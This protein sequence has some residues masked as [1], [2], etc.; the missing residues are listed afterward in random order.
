MYDGLGGNALKIR[1]CIL[2]RQWFLGRGNPRPLEGVVPGAFVHVL[3][4]D[5]I[6]SLQVVNAVA[7]RRQRPFRAATAGDDNLIVFHQGDA[8]SP[9]ITYVCPSQFNPPSQAFPFGTIRYAP[10]PP[11]APHHHLVL[12]TVLSWRS[13]ADQSARAHAQTLPGPQI[14]HTHTKFVQDVRYA[15]SGDHFASVGSDGKV[16]LYEGKA[17]ET[18]GE[19]SGGHSGTAVSQVRHASFS[20]S[21]LKHAHCGHSTRSA[22]APIARLYRLA[23]PMEPSSCVRLVLHALTAA[24]SA[25]NDN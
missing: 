14:I 25:Q 23:L 15:P 17:G 1:T 21:L 16:F 3:I 6:T 12:V 7:I 9:H 10:P 11:S 8:I 4:E 18:L 5:A 24:N 20:L 2:V 13:V 22:G 19:F